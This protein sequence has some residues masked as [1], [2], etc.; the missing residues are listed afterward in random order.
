MDERMEGEWIK[1]QRGK[2]ERME[3]EYMKEWTGNG[4]MKG[5][6]NVMENVGEWMKKLRD[7]NKIMDRNVFNLAVSNINV[8]KCFYPSFFS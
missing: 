6:E 5:G 7:K 1:E 4:S 8:F 3:G 2:D